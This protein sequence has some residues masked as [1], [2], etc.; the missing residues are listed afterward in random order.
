L[1]RAIELVFNTPSHHRVHHGS[2]D[3]YL[4]YGGIL[5]PVNAEQRD[6]ADAHGDGGCLRRACG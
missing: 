3:Q 2:Q 1:G 6:D 5:I 4:E